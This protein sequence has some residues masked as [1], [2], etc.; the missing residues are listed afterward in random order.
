MDIDQ[1]IGIP[2][3]VMN[4]VLHFWF[5]PT[6]LFAY[7]HQRRPPHV[8]GLA[9]QR[10]MPFLAASMTVCIL[11]TALIW[12]MACF[13]TTVWDFS[14]CSV[15]SSHYILLNML[16]EMTDAVSHPRRQNV[17]TPCYELPWPLSLT[18][19]FNGRG[20][21]YLKNAAILS[22]STGVAQGCH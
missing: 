5:L 13:A 22:L 20:F 9:H 19:L 6:R 12:E 8:C 3:N 1:I 2:S 21:V 10:N 16:T 7:L 15:F 17:V 11:I 18:M 14:L 4:S